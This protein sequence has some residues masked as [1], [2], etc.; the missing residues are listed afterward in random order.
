MP[1][2]QALIQSQGG[3]PAMF[4]GD[5]S[6]NPTGIIEMFFTQAEVRTALT[7]NIIFPISA[8]GAPPSPVVQA[9]L[10][11]I[12]PSVVFSGPAGNVTIAP[13]GTPV[14]ETSWLPLALVGT[15]AL[16]FIGWAVFGK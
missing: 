12:Q 7:P 4:N 10:N 5:G 8:H 11:Q 2:A 9:L 13:Y 1:V 14:G 15:G 6:I 16:L 3:D